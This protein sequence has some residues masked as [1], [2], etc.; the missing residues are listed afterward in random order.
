MVSLQRLSLL[1]L[2][3]YQGTLACPKFSWPESII[4]KNGVYNRLG[5]IDRGV[6]PCFHGD[7]VVQRETLQNSFEKR[8]ARINVW[9]N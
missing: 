6:K 9:I 8:I 2:L 5:K 1:G 7:I 3:W 4:C